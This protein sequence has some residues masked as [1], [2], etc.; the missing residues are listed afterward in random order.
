M[1]MNGMRGQLKVYA[2]EIVQLYEFNIYEDYV[3]NY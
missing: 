3:T 2:G 1:L